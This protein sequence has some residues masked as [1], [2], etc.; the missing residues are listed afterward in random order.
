MSSSV[1]NEPLTLP[2]QRPPGRRR[3][4]LSPRSW[5]LAAYRLLHHKKVG[6]SLILAMGL[7]AL[8]GVLFPQ[9]GPE[10]RGDD[11][12]YDAWLE[13]LRPRYGGW[14]TPLSLAGAF[15]MF[16][17]W[18]FRIV[19]VLLAASIVAC[20]AHRLPLLW[21]QATRPHT[22]VSDAFFDHARL[23]RTV[24]V[25]YGADDALERIRHS[26][27]RRGFRVLRDERDPAHG[28]YADRFRFA[29][30]GTVLAHA[31]FVII[32]LGVLVSAT[33]GFRDTSFTVPVGA[34][35]AVGHGTGLEVQVLSF[36]DTYHADGRPKDYVSEVVLRRDGRQ[37]AQQEVRVNTPLRHDGV[38]INQSYF[39]IAAA[40]RV[41]GA[42][43]Q[44]LAQA[45][46][47]LEFRS[48]DRAYS[49]GVLE[50]AQQG[51]EAYVVTP[52]SGQVDPQIGAGQVRVE[53]YPADSTVPL[54][55]TV[56]TQGQPTTLEGLEVTFL[57]EQQFTGL[58]VSRDPGASWVWVGATLLVLGTFLTMFLR[59]HRVWVRVRADGERTIVRIGCPDRPDIAFE[60]RFRAIVEDLG[61]SP[62]TTRR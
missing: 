24:E 18:P 59:F 8:V 9:A 50:L 27:R 21:A 37:V 54:T 14:T 58:M 62:V 48:E 44:V 60:S 33:T 7:L 36:T 32:L 17:S 61:G 47:P 20:T 19:T 41:A 22:H 25:P 1:V 23:G 5:P 34:T 26:L 51:L 11:A 13:G 4:G 29:P 57:R 6:L 45:A 10:L 53:L 2:D 31:A 40:M 42:D 43:G 28:L 3:A 35:R 38:K 15:T 39:G 16:S 52:A 49:Y 56:I 30:L 12:A 46:V 55:S